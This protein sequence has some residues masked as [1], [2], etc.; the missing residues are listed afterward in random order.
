MPTPPD[1]HER[2][3]RI[4]SQVGS[5]VPARLQRTLRSGRRRR[6]VRR[7]TGALVTM[8]ILAVS[9]AAV[10]IMLRAP[11][12]VPAVPTPTVPPPTAIHNGP[13]DLPTAEGGVRELAAD[14]S[15]GDWVVH[16][17]DRC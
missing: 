3:Q 17:G 11:K 16:C 12:D 10:W 2:F 9:I 15:L 1:L 5:D 8:T 13:I 6:V 7:A 4:G 14:G